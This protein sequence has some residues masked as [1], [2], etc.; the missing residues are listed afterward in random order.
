M[1]RVLI[2]QAG[3]TP[4]AGFSKIVQANGSAPS[5]FCGTNNPRQVLEGREK[6]SGLCPVTMWPSGAF[7]FLNQKS[8]G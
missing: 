2:A 6:K 4:E 5:G 8:G 7:A 3:C 1:G